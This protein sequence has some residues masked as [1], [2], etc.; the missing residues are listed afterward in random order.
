[1]RIGVP[2]EIKKQESRVGLT[3]ESVG[4]LVRAGHE[5]SVQS[6]AGIGS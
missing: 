2:T 6:G 5:V 4:E 1:M 3:P